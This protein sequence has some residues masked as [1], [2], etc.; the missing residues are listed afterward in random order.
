MKRSVFSIFTNL[1]LFKF[2]AFLIHIKVHGVVR[3]SWE[4]LSFHHTGQT[5]DNLERKIL[6]LVIWLFTSAF[7]K[8]P[9]KKQ[10]TQTQ[11]NKQKQ[12]KPTTPN[13]HNTKNE[14]TVWYSESLFLS[15]RF[16]VIHRTTDQTE[17]YH[18]WHIHSPIRNMSQLIPHHDENHLQMKLVFPGKRSWNKNWHKQ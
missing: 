6:L 9:R 3:L 15:K 16:T 10:Q 13:N 14:S 5:W 4:R 2:W 17:S 11:T 18:F 12:K 7:T 8:H 1:Q